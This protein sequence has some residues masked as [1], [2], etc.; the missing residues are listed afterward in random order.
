MRLLALLLLI[1]TAWADQPN[2]CIS[3][4]NLDIVYEQEIGPGLSTTGFELQ[5]R[6]DS[7]SFVQ[8]YTGVDTN[9]TISEM[10]GITFAHKSLYEFRVRS[11]N[12]TEQSAWSEITDQLCVYVT[13][14]P[15]TPGDPEIDE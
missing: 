9:I 7:G 5:A 3:S 8:V 1:S 14:A 2:T 15:S 6:E 11:Y 13:A 12:D 10:S 4:L